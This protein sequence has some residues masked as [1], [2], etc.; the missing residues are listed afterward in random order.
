MS[1]VVVRWYIE[2]FLCQ[3]RQWQRIVAILSRIKHLSNTTR[4]SF[5]KREVDLIIGY[6][7]DAIWLWS[8]HITRI[9]SRRS[10][11]IST[12][13]I[14]RLFELRA[15][16]IG[17]SSLGI[18]KSIKLLFFGSVY[19]NTRVFYWFHTLIT[20]AVL[21]QVFVLFVVYFYLSGRPGNML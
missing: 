5:A 2:I 1:I 11:Q 3:D 13:P 17:V 4:L 14:R 16:R 20:E 21:G 18:A 10:E 19:S 8:F 12:Q 9:W 7:T 15:V 6:N